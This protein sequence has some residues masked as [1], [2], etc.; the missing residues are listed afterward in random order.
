MAD[1]ATLTA[2]ITALEAA[3][4]RH[5]LEV[6]FADRR[7]RYRPTA[8]IISQI[9]YYRTQLR[10]SYSRPRQFLGVAGRGLV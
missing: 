1:S 3:L 2:K 4:D 10:D 6:E 8:E 7:V 5:E 9:D